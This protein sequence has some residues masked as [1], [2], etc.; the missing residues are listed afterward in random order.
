MGCTRFTQT[1][2]LRFYDHNRNLKETS[3]S[4]PKPPKAYF[5][6]SSEK[7]TEKNKDPGFSGNNQK[8]KK[9]K[10]K[11]TNIML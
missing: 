7:F 1:E 11:Q 3:S 9:K 4:S 2:V 8:K 10:N 6:R 5:S